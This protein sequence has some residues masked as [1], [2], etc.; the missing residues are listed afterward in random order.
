[1]PNDNSVKRVPVDFNYLAINPDFLKALA[2][3]ARYAEE[4]YGSWHQYT[5]ARL[6]GEKSCINHIY[7]HLRCYQLGEPHDKFGDVKMHLAAIAYNCLMEWFY[8]EKFG[9]V[10]HPLKVERKARQPDEDVAPIEA[11]L[12][13]VPRFHV[14]AVDGEKEEG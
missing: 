14:G 6:E 1:M 10:E 2:Q 5:A 8:H 13:R 4:K 11:S 3:I 12:R 9:S 7:E